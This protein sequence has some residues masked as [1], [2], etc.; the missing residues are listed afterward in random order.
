MTQFWGTMDAHIPFYNRSLADYLR[1]AKET[2]IA[3]AATATTTAT[4]A[5]ATATA[6]AAA[7]ATA[8]TAAAPTTTA[9]T[10]AMARRGAEADDR[11]PSGRGLGSPV[12]VLFMTDDKDIVDS[13]PAAAAEVGGVEVFTVPTGRPLISSSAVRNSDVG[14]K[15]HEK[16]CKG[17]AKGLAKGGSR[18]STK[19][20]AAVVDGTSGERKSASAS[21]S[22]SATNPTLCAFDYLRDP[23]TGKGVGQ[24]ELIQLLVTFEIMKDCNTFVSGSFSSHFTFLIYAWLCSRRPVREWGGE[25]GGG[26]RLGPPL[27]PLAPSTCFPV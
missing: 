21:A 26:P 20:G 7:T 8:T 13:A 22:A 4:T 12:K 23:L 18:S 9:T 15:N 3:T 27:L 5:T 10:T 25:W 11:G 17:A 16:N 2:A 1:F 24:E 6:T 19:T 14:A